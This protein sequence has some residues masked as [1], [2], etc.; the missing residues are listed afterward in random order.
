MTVQDL[1][2]ELSALMESDPTWMDAKVCDF[3]AINLYTAD[4]IEHSNE[5]EYEESYDEGRYDELNYDPYM[6]CDF[7]EG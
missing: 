5:E 6:G 7:F 2:V 1:V 4:I 3:Q